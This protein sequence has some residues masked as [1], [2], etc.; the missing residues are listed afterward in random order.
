MKKPCGFIAALFLA[1]A[2]G[3]AGRQAPGTNEKL[4]N[5]FQNGDTASILKIL[6][7]DPSQL[8]ADL[9]E[10][11]TPLHYAAYMGNET[12]FDYMM[13]RGADLHVKDRRGLTP[14]WFT[15]SGGRPAM[16]KKLIALGADLGVRDAE[17]NTLLHRATRLRNAEAVEILLETSGRKIEINAQNK[18]GYTP[19]LQA[20]LIGNG[21]AIQALVRHGAD[22][23]LA[24]A[25]G[26]TPVFLAVEKGSI[27]LVN[28]LL[29]QKPDMNV[30]E[31][32]TGKTLLHEAAISGKS[33]IVGKLLE[34]GIPQN[35]KDK[36]GRTALSYARRYGNKAAAEVLIKSGAEDAAWRTDPKDPLFLPWGRILAE[37]RI[38]ADP[39]CR[40]IDRDGRLDIV[41]SDFLN[42]ARIL[43]N[44]AGFEFKKAVPLTSAPEMATSGH[45]L[46]WGDFNGDGRPDLFLAYNNRFPARMLFGDGTGKFADSG[47]GIGTLPHATSVK[48]ADVDGDKDLDVFITYYQTTGRLFLNDGHGVMKESDQILPVRFEVGDLDGDGDVDLVSIPNA[49]GEP[50]FLWRN[51]QGRFSRLDKPLAVGKG[52][53]SIDPADVD[54][55]GDLDLFAWGQT[56][57]GSIWLNNGSGS[58]SKSEQEFN[59]GRAAAGDIDSDGKP[60]L[61]VG[62]CLWLNK[63][64]ARFERMQ[65]LSSGNRE[66]GPQTFLDIDGDGDLDLLA[67][68]S[69]LT[70]GKLDVALFINTLRGG[71]AAAMAER[72]QLP[73]ANPDLLEYFESGDTAGILKILEA[74]PQQL[75]A[76]L[77]EGMTPLHYAAYMG[78]ETVFDYMMKHGADLQ[79]KDKRG[80][81]PVW[82]TVSGKRPAML[83]K[84]IA[85]GSDLGIKDAQGNTLL[86]RATQRRGYIELIEILLNNL[87]GGFE[88]N[89]KNARGFTPL[90]QAVCSNIQDAVQAL[91]VRGADVNLADSNGITPMLMAVERGAS[92]L[93]D[94]LLA[95]KAN[96]SVIDEKTGR[97]LLHEAAVSGNSA[98]VSKLLEAGIPQNA[99]DKNGR[100]ALSYAKKYGNTAAADVLKKSGVE[101]VPWEAKPDES[102]FLPQG[103]LLAEGRIFANPICY[104]FDGD[105]RT[106]IAVSDFLN[107]ARIVFND[108]GFE[109]K[110]VVPLTSAPEMATSGHGVAEGDFN[111]DGWVDLFLVY[112][113]RFP[114]RLLLGDGRGGFKDSG[115]GIGT[116][117][118]G[119]S[120]EAADVDGDKDLDVF[121]TY[122]DQARLYLNDG[123]GVMAES[124]QILPG[125]FAVGDFDG[126]GDADLIS[127]PVKEG[128]PIFLW[129]NEKGR[130]ITRTRPIVVGKGAFWVDLADADGD[131]DLDL[132]VWG[133]REEAAEG[134]LWFNDGRGLFRKS[135]QEFDSGQIAAGDVNGD[136]I[137]DLVFGPGVWL[138]KGSGRFEKVQTLPGASARKLVDIDGDG[139]LDLLAGRGDIPAGKRD[140]VLFINN[141]RNK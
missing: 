14:I 119:T 17:G 102:P 77:E 88:I 94:H 60:D 126:D 82:F 30:I 132:F 58:F 97:S 69:D 72:P 70:I 43:Y 8:K 65:T 22:V 106:D 92:D 28:L 121:I 128:E 2:T 10:G 101:D 84:L 63:G 68:V 32:K 57:Q 52:I 86:H 123:A 118:H 44:D 66:I 122:P 87:G 29:S 139:D 54:G 9:E 15:V 114:A 45:G 136:G 36:N 33:D 135:E 131:A 38:F 117:P 124:N 140:I 64:G 4:L 3:L 96:L 7:A 31:E 42:P 48:V 141:L 134:S 99:K 133:R 46:G 53:F 79:A 41:F 98:V 21:G 78:N 55:D 120:A 90:M 6:E 116:L 89:D 108:S 24:A 26:P 13:K 74:D 49:N 85:L 104:D 62:P 11:M 25:D 1:L 129:L 115:R 34:A 12:V 125:R 16:L 5:L 111:G 61:A 127:A 37:G 35:A 109:F 100:T 76:D 51:D 73:K 130:M 20:I 138:G 56:A 105:G 23:N 110:K 107:P 50:A 71:E 67:G 18:K 103:R 112:N 59:S 137:L 47:R 95:R 83:K 39:V 113:N 80:L 91:A 40:D 81:T 19:L 27:D 75:K 93:I